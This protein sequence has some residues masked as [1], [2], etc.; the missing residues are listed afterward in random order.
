MEGKE[1]EIGRGE[2]GGPDH[3]RPVYMLGVW[4]LSQKLWGG[5]CQNCYKQG[6][7]VNKLEFQL[8]VLAVAYRM[9]WREGLKSGDLFGGCCRNPGMRLEGSEEGVAWRE[10]GGYTTD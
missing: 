8:M 3:T 2:N 4:I 6:N 1:R 5:G 7:E 9:D 10:R